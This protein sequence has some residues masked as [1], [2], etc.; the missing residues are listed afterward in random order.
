MLK[1]AQDVACAPQKIGLALGLAAYQLFHFALL[2]PTSVVARLLRLFGL[3]LFAHCALCLLAFFLF[4]FE[5]FAM[6]AV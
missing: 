2:R 5:V 3:D 4:N 6:S 1:R